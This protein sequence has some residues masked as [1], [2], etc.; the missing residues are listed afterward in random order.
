MNLILICDFGLNR[1]GID[2]GGIEKLKWGRDNYCTNLVIQALIILQKLNLPSLIILDYFSISP[3][4]LNV[5]RYNS[6][7]AVQKVSHK[8]FFIFELINLKSNTD[9]LTIYKWKMI[10]KS[11][12][13]VYK[14]ICIDG[15][16]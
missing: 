2:Q 15:Y 9:C 5:K 13:S 3:W 14:M 7:Y 12:P 11:P 1:T 8:G 6:V 10:N 4:L 16:C